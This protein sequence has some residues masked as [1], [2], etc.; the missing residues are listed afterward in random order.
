MW[1]LLKWCFLHLKILCHSSMCLPGLIIATAASLSSCHRRSG[2]QTHPSSLDKI[3]SQDDWRLLLGI[4]GFSN[5]FLHQVTEL[6]EEEKAKVLKMQ[7]TDMSIE[8]RRMWFNAMARKFA[9]KMY[10][11]T[12]PPGALEKYQAASNGSK[13]K[14]EMLKQFICD[15]SLQ[16]VGYIYLCFLVGSVAN[17]V[18]IIREIFP[19][20]I[21]AKYGS[22]GLLHQVQGLQI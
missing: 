1:M 17:P 14:F 8:D 18:N 9:N 7:K 2:R 19:N 6:S 20:H 16:L 12:L 5:D 13:E 22:W 15:E 4:L 3:G 11:A 21:E 10:V